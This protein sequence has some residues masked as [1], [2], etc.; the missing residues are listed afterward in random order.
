MARTHVGAT[1]NKILNPIEG[2]GPIEPPPPNTPPRPA[3]W[4]GTRRDSK[5]AFGCVVVHE[6]H[7]TKAHLIEKFIT[8]DVGSAYHH[9]PPRKS[10][11]DSAR[12]QLPPPPPF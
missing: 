4:D 6:P 5:F 12:F 2:F 11:D 10:G 1:F 7:F 3:S 9:A 8:I